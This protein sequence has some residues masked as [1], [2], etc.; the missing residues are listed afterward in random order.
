MRNAAEILL[1]Q[2]IFIFSSSGDEVELILL[3]LASF[4]LPS[5][6]FNQIEGN[7]KHYATLGASRTILPTVLGLTLKLLALEI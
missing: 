6:I 3:L 1:T 7:Y 2:A 4:F 5:L